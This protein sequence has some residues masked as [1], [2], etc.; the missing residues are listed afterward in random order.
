MKKL[1]EEKTKNLTDIISKINQYSNEIK[2]LENEGLMVQGELRI[3][4]KLESE[5]TNPKKKSK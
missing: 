4:N 5:K 3:L 2:K 1:I